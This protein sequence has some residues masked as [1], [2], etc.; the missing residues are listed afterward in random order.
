MME[1][2]DLEFEVLFVRGDANFDMKSG[3]LDLPKS[4]LDSKKCTS[5]KCKKKDKCVYHKIQ[6]IGITKQ[7]QKYIKFKYKG[8]TFPEI[9]EFSETRYEEEI[10][11]KLL[12]VYENYK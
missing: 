7:C 9:S 11:P 2:L 8:D 10:F 5:G 12:K 1:N 6:G 3:R 4:I